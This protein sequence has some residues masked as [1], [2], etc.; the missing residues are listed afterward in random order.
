MLE[1]RHVGPGADY[2]IDPEVEIQLTDFEIAENL[3]E[4]MTEQRHQNSCSDR[5]A[6]RPRLV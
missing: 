3:G 1:E 5:D 6:C 4:R 2:L